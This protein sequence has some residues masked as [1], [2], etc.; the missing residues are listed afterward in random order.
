MIKVQLASLNDLSPMLEYGRR[1]FEGSNYEGLGYNSVIARKTAKAALSMPSMCVY[2]AKKNGVICGLIIG[3]MDA[4]PFCAGMSATDLVFH[5]EAGG[6]KL[7]DAFVE[8][9]KRKKVTRIDMGVSQ[10]GNDEAVT[11]LYERKGF[12]AAG[13]LFYQQEKVK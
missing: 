8:W 12:K 11:K 7:L 2:L 4:M 6:D 13:R 10:E 3:M 9:C 5:A 1:A